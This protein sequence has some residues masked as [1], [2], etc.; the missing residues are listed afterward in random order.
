MALSGGVGKGLALLAGVGFTA[1]CIYAFGVS[2]RLGFEGQAQR[3]ARRELLVFAA[4]MAKCGVASGLPE[5]SGR[6]PAK[7]ADVSAKVYSSKPEDWDD[8]SFE[9][10][11]YRLKEPQR[12]QYRWYKHGE[13]VGTVEARGD[14]DGNGAP[15]TWYEIRVTCSKLGQCEAANYVSSVDEDGLREPPAILRWLGRSQSFLGEP[16]SLTADDEAPPPPSAQATAKPLDVV[17]PG[18]P[19]PLNTLYFDA[20]R[21]AASKLAGAVLL[22]LEYKG[23]RERLGDPVR[24][25]SV[26]GFYGHPDKNGVVAVGSEVVR[27]SYDQAGF[28]EAL[29]KAPRELHAVGFAECLPEKLILALEPPAALTMTLAWSKKHERAIW[30]TQG[31]KSSP[32]TYGADKCALVKD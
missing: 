15:D 26:R 17:K 18:E 10:A 2:K 5:T 23:A 12:M 3:E 20:E 16:P 6:V 29:T 30:T 11:D 1:G 25:L 8:P 13:S 14:L 24:G 27:V 32:M 4:K 7:L 31:G 22:E 9:C 19:T 28:G 21:R